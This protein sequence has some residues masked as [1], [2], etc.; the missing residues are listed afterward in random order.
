M[1]QNQ[2]TALYTEHTIC[3][4]TTKMD[5]IAVIDELLT[6]KITA[7]RYAQERSTKVFDPIAE[8]KKV[9]LTSAKASAGQDMAPED[10]AVGF[11]S[12]ALITQFGDDEADFQAEYDNGH[13]NI[14]SNHN[15]L[16]ADGSESDTEQ[17]E[18]NVFVSYNKAGGKSEY[19]KSERKKQVVPQCP[20]CLSNGDTKLH[21]SYDLPRMFLPRKSKCTYLEII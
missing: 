9:N 16:V 8:V 6:R 4:F 20:L 18:G 21:G 7:I 12:T 10:L 15:D 19:K 5:T 2:L 3:P 11:T 17:L 14:Y 1:N 13:P